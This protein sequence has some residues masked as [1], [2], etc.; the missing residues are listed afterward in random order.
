MTVAVRNAAS[1]DAALLHSLAAAT[2][3]L[4]CPPGTL[5]SDIDDFVAQQLSEARFAEYLADAHRALL[6]AEVDGVPAGYT[7]LVFPKSPSADPLDPDV[8]SAVLARPTAELSKVY[9]LADL[10]GR[11]V[12]AALMAASVDAVRARGCASVWLGVN[13]QNTRANRFYEKS[14]FV[15]V[16]AKKFLLGGKWEDD[17]V[18]ERIL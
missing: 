3:A 5:Q 8:A 10:H 15:I 14:G 12:A 9:V 6:I 11:G 17:F 1:S 18:R 4:A 7:M 13:Q 2:F 16:G